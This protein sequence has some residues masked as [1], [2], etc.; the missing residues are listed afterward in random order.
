LP[1]P[2]GV[3]WEKTMETA[4]DNAESSADLLFIRGAVSI[5]ARLACVILGI[6]NVTKIFLL[7]QTPW[8]L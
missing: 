3:H 4:R 7:L 6:A 8:S 1:L 5:P 2:A